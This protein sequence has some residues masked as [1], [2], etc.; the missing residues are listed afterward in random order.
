MLN[1][2]VRSKYDAWEEKK[3]M[4]KDEATDQYVAKVSEPLKTH[5]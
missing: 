2:V 5:K 4:S 1:M 3:R